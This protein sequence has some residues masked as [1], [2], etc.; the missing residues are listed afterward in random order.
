MLQHATCVSGVQLANL[1]RCSLQKKHLPFS[2]IQKIM[3]Q[4]DFP[5]GWGLFLLLC[6][7]PS[8][9]LAFQ[10]NESPLRKQ[11]QLWLMALLEISDKRNI[12]C[13]Q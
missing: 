2:L 7:T 5:W 4:F 10:V 13:I 11:H 9:S 6:S 3:A 8:V 1:E 12:P